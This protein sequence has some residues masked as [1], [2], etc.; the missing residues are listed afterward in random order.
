MRSNRRALVAVGLLV[1]LVALLLVAFVDAD[2]VE[3][4]LTLVP[5]IEGLIMVAIGADTHR[6]FGG[7][8]EA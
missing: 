1:A 5:W 7:P 8:R 3:P 4:I 6:R 2:R